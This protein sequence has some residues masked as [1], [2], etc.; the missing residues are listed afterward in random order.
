MI[1]IVSN[2]YFYTVS[3]CENILFEV[4]LMKKSVIYCETSDL[5][6]NQVIILVGRVNDKDLGRVNDKDLGRVNDKDLGRVNDKDLGRVND[7]DLGRVNDK[8]LGRVNLIFYT[9]KKYEKI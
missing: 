7:K 9:C 3:K 5:S 6:R 4:L 8:D 2:I 1:K